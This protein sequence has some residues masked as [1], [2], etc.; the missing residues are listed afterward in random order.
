[1]VF[2]IIYI[3]SINFMRK[4]LYYED[5]HVNDDDTA[6]FGLIH[7]ANSYGFLEQIGYFYL[8]SDNN[9]L[10]KINMPFKYFQ[11]KVKNKYEKYIIYLT[12]EF[13]FILDVLRI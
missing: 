11:M 12:D 8:Q 1:M 5:Y 10:E 4:D 7:F 6:F 2:Y 9:T 3:K 13:E